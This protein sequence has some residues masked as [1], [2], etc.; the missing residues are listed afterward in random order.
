MK[1]HLLIQIHGNNSTELK[2]FQKTN[3][4][5][6]PIVPVTKKLTF[7]TSPSLTYDLSDLLNSS[8]E[9]LGK[10]TFGA[11]YKI[12]LNSGLMLVVK[13]L[14]E[15]QLPESEF[16]RGV[17]RIGELEHENLMPLNAYYYSKDETLLVYDFVT[18]L[19]DVLHGNQTS[20]KVP[21][22][23]ASRANIALTSARGISHI[24][25]LSPFSSHGN[26]KSSNILLSKS[27]KSHKSHESYESLVSDTRLYFLASPIPSRIKTLNRA[28]E[29]TDPTKPSQKADVYSFGVL[30]LELLT[31]W[32]SQTVDLVKW[33]QYELRDGWVNQV[34]DEELLRD[35]NVKDE[36]LV[37][38]LQIAIDCTERFP[39]LRPL[40]HVVEARIEAILE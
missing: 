25:S 21:L 2:N 18:S 28:P 29:I 23:W 4:I 20:N 32:E 6:E 34:I 37:E 38:F 35:G 19:A 40:M 7:F 31:G 8:A 39:E 15:V 14:R 36:E 33:V 16:R 10:G 27:Y 22:N 26:I 1:F 30:L 5:Q 3:E 13:R 11:T 17:E 12:T 9:V 24:H